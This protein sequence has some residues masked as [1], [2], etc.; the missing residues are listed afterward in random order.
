MHLRIYA[1][2]FEID[3]VRAHW[4]IY[5]YIYKYAYIYT[6]TMH[7]DIHIHIQEKIMYILSTR[8]HMWMETRMYVDDSYVYGFTS[9]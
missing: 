3:C 7:I 2:L 6:Y 4:Y 1:P 8:M 5:I 9:V